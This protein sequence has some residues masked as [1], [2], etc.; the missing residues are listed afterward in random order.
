MSASEDHPGDA[1]TTSSTAD[2]GATNSDPGAPAGT[3]V[4]GADL[5]RQPAPA[6]KADRLSDTGD[7]TRRLVLLGGVA[8]LIGALVVAFTGRDERSAAATPRRRGANRA[9]GIEGWEYGVPLNPGKRE[10]ARRR[11]GL[12]GD[13]SYLDDEL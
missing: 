11:A 13:Y 9:F 8:M 10:L 5:N 12:S 2:A 7:S 3:D 1:T 4:N 6:R